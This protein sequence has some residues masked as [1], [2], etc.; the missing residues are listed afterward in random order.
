[1]RAG[2]KWVVVFLAVLG[3]LIFLSLNW[4]S[5]QPKFTYHSEIWGDRAGYHVYLPA[6]FE[7][8][9]DATRFPESMDQRTGQGFALD[10]L[11]GR[12][13]T[14]YTSG[15]AILRAPFYLLGSWFTASDDPGGAG[16]T[17]VD[18]AMVNVSAAF[19]CS[20]GLALLF[21]I[22]RRRY[23][24]GVVIWSLLA[25]LTGTNLLF[26]TIGDSG[27]SH[28][29][30]FFLFAL[31]T[32]LIDRSASEPFTPL[33]ALLL[34]VVAGL[35]VL[36]R[37]TNVLFLPLP[38]LFLEGSSGVVR[39]RAR[40]IF[41]VGNILWAV[42][43]GLLVWLP[44]MAYWVYAF[45]KPLVWSYGQE[46]FPYLLEPRMI[47]FWFAPYNGLFLYNP[48]LLVLFVL[49]PVVAKT[50][51][52]AAATWIAVLGVSYICASW[53]A[54][55]FGCGFGSRNF[56]EYAAL[57]AFPVCEVLGTTHRA[58]VLARGL[59]LACCLY[60]LKLTL[61]CSNCWFGEVWDW[62]MFGRLLLGPFMV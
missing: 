3:T 32:Y 40:A 19:Y 58:K 27:M 9:F 35:V 33:A 59:V 20:C 24:L 48:L 8:G 23:P 43:G 13:V 57:F 15:V 29:Y 41:S 31:W 22:L 61:S 17:L 10:T 7:Y 25:I 14:K 30:S 38:V 47:P 18:H 26:Y 4:H 44:Q 50:R 11:S 12:V 2:G 39:L 55:T 36:L 60:T 21:L 28:V 45:G 56:V 34:G 5:H 49:I 53:F 42:M 54:W 37:P 62:T 16:F 52:V 51:G 1:M 6:L 46:G